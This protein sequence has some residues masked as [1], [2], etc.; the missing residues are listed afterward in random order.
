SRLR[1]VAARLPARL[2]GG[3]G[4]H[5]DGGGGDGGRRDVRGGRRLLD[6]RRVALPVAAQ[7]RHR[8]EAGLGGQRRAPIAGAAVAGEADVEVLLAAVRRIAEHLVVDAVVAARA[9]V[10]RLLHG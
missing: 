3:A 5:L 8:A 9:A 6:G 4:D 1:H 7:L 10:A 2:A